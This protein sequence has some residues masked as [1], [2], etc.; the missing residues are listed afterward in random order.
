M[1]I[2]T[3]RR[4]GEAFGPM[5]YGGS[6]SG[7]GGGRP[8]GTTSAITEDIHDRE[9]KETWILAWLEKAYQT[10]DRGR[11]KRRTPTQQPRP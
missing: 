1:S 2:S 11:S 5:A 8:V 7:N 3:R 4:T 9:S 6:N 10:E